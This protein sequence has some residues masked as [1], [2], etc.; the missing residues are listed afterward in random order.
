[1]IGG[2]VFV[3]RAFAVEGVRR[4]WEVTVFNRGRSQADPPGV[5]VL[6]GDRTDAADLA[7]MAA[8]GPY[9]AVVD[10][11]GYVPREVG[12]S[13]AA[14]AG[15][16]DAYLFVSTINVYPGYPALPTDE[17]SP[18]QGGTADAGPED[19]DYGWLKDGCEKAVRQAF[20]GRVVVLQPGLIVGPHDRARRTAAWLRRAALGGPMAVPGTPD[21]PLRVID[22]RDLAAFGLD[23]LAGA[24]KDEVEDYMVP[25]APDN[26]N[27]GDYLD[28]CVAATGNRAELVYVDDRHFVDHGVE[29]W[30]EL[31]LWLPPA[32]QTAAVW[33]ASCA[34]ALAAGLRCRPVTDSVRD[35]AAWLFAP[36][37]EQEAFEDYK[38]FTQWTPFL[39][40]D[41][42]RAIL[43]AH[44]TEQSRTR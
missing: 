30:T 22:V 12:K 1:M 17:S 44:A 11:C 42:E 19:G 34:K 15:H 26:G 5:R 33:T 35:T 24:P 41:K 39:S 6:R 23:L 32:P 28:A 18:R 36:G 29:P 20:P 13:A 25:G 8:A 16:A 21:R 7:A 3:G 14:L 9:D 40:P 31:P 43:A 10:V 27:W 4:G 38:H 2:S 37:G